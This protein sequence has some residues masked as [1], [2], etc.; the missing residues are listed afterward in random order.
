MV[1]L[2]RFIKKKTRSLDKPLLVLMSD[3]FGLLATVVDNREGEIT[4]VAS[5]RSGLYEPEAALAEVF[6]QLSVTFG[7]LP[8]ETILLHAHAVPSL[9]ELSIENIE[10]IEPEKLN[11]LV[12]WE[13]DSVF[14][15][16]VPHDNLGWLMIGLGFITEQQR[17]DLIR[18]MTVENTQNR[19]KLRFGDLAIAEGYI[20]RNQLE[21]CLKLQD[22]LQLQ[23]QRIKCGWS[24]FD[25]N[26]NKRWLATAMNDSIHEK[27]ITA[28]KS[29]SAKGALGKTHLKSYYPYV[30]AGSSQLFAIFS[31]ENIYVLE[32]HRPYLALLTYR[33]GCLIDS[34][35]LECSNDTPQL[36]DVETLLNNADVSEGSDIYTTVTHADRNDLRENLESLTLFHFKHLEREVVIPTQLASDVSSAE[37]IMIFGA[38]FNYLS[39]SHQLMVP[40]QGANPPPPLYKRPQTKVAAIVM[41]CACV[42][43]GIEGGFAWKIHK[44]QAKL[45]G[46]KEKIKLHEDLKKDLKDSKKA[47]AKYE[48]LIAEQSGMAELKKLME[49]VLVSRKNFMD[50]F[51]DM[52]VLNMNDNLIL[53]S[54]TENRWNEFVIDGWSVDQASVE[55][56]NQGL[57]RD[58]AV[59]D[60]EITENPSELTR[61]NKGFTGYKFKFVIKKIPS[62][63]SDPSIDIV[64]T[65]NT[66]P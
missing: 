37:A 62:A 63:L 39:R 6:G 64:T 11:E 27:W 36:N 43:G 57:A 13:M 56:F 32:L 51:L 17:D 50:Q 48:I 41:L 59:W 18:K 60:M 1:S 55:Y 49:S 29:V 22:Q 28:L 65:G 19:K 24:S 25:I 2:K 44:T 14:S 35:V 5:A 9:L 16:L 40:V 31:D 58:L 15:D 45:D 38:T 42:F 54:I 26:N 61:S 33:N 34:L 8:K 66:V 46:V 23:N 20:N 47:Q 52:V 53:D 10:T 12:R 30:G 7:K 4:I 21:Q 3:G